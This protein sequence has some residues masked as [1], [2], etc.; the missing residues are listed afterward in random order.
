M[1]PRKG[2]TPRQTG[3]LTVN[4]NVTWT[5]ARLTHRPDD[6]VS[7]HL[8]NVDRHPTKNTVVYPRRLW[9]SYSPPSELD[10]SHNRIKYKQSARFC[11]KKLFNCIRKSRSHYIPALVHVFSLTQKVD[12]KRPLA[13][14]QSHAPSLL[15]TRA[16]FHLGHIVAHRCNS[17]LSNY[18]IVI[19][20]Q[21]QFADNSVISYIRK[22]D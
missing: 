8:W 17:L 11:F 6:G 1:S 4:C 2:S 20:W 16:E 22:M 14:L 12:P 5:W 13:M 15:I 10:I 18:R 19:K 3:W 9:A 21:W 7:T